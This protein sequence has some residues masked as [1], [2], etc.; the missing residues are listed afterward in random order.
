MHT[1]LTHSTEDRAVWALSLSN[2][3]REN[4]AEIKRP[5]SY[6]KLIFHLSLYLKAFLKTGMPGLQDGSA[7]KDTSHKA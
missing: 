6:L 2:R 7:G 4:Q 1:S 5:T 3:G